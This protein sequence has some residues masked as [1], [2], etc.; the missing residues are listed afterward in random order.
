M[1]YKIR[2]DPHPNSIS[3]LEDKHIPFLHS[4]TDILLGKESTRVNQLDL[5]I[6]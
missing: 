4:M 5:K 6:L 2:D 1:I 3:Y